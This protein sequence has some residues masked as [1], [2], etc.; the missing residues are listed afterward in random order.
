MSGEAF[1]A[2]RVSALP[3]MSRT[4][5][6]GTDIICGGGLRYACPPSADSKRTAFTQRG[7]QQRRKTGR[8]R[9]LDCVM[10]PAAT[11]PTCTAR[12]VRLLEALQSWPISGHKARKGKKV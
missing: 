1:Q 5:V 8:L 3:L 7:K 9:C 6:A 12:A 2:S 4:L 11:G 10:C